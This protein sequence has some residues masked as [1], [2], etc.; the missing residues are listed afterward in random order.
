MKIFRRSSDPVEDVLRRLS[1]RLRWFRPSLDDAP[2]PLEQLGHL[3]QHRLCPAIDQGDAAP[4]VTALAIA[5]DAMSA[6]QADEVLTL[7]LVEV[8]SDWCSWPETPP[9]VVATIEDRMDPL[10]RARWNSIRA[11]GS[12]AAAWIRSE[13]A[14]ASQPP[15]TYQEIENP[16][17]RF[18][19]RSTYQYIDE[20]M[21]VGTAARLRFEKST[22][23]GVQ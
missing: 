19:V 13:V 6:A 17:L 16:D 14:S 11:Q 9:E 21:T 8:L 2:T 3:A 7:G 10:T 1:K 20:T 5:E 18:L 4:A 15:V 22:G 23:R 12:A